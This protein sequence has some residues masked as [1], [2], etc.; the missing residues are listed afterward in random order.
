[1]WARGL[2]ADLFPYQKIIP[3]PENMKK[4]NKNVLTEHIHYSSWVNS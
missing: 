4:K 1:M 2:L 3:F